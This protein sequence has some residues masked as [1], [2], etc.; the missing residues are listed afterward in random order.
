MAEVY[1]YGHVSTGKLLRIKGDYPAA[2]GY[3]EVV[4]ALE[5]HC[6]E[7]TGSALVLRRLGVSVALEG[8]WIGD[9]PEC[10]G[11]LAF[12]RERGIDCSGLRVVPGYVGATELV[13]SDG[14]SR[15]VF[16]RYIDLLFTT[17]QWDEAD[18]AKIAAAR[19]ACIDSTFGESTLAAARLAAARKVPVVTFDPRHDS[20]LT[21][22]SAAVVIS[23]ELIHREYPAAAASEAE[24]AQ[25]FDAYRQQCPGL[26]VFTAGSRPI[27]WAR[28]LGEPGD[29]REQAPYP[30]EVVDSA[31]AGDSFRGGIIYGMLQGW[32]DAEC[33]RFAAATA[34]LICTRAPGC[35]NPPSLEEIQALLASGSASL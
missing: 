33:V 35:V 5:N 34:A 23:G 18:P 7:A 22:L 30:V 11:T 2:D 12:L 21:R 27:W 31:G 17:K 3:A 16:G 15:T 28:G 26:V 8:N 19:I 25:L 24:R 20:E 32:P 13:V 9:N 1:C 29:R 14:K 10:R 6:G 4:E